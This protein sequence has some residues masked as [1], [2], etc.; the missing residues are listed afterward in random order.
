[1]NS[2]NV[3]VACAGQ[4]AL[5]ALCLDE[6][7]GDPTDAVQLRAR[8]TVS[9]ALACG[10]SGPPF[11]IEV[12]ASLLGLLVRTA[13]FG[14]AQFEGLIRGDAIYVRPGLAPARRRYVIAHEIIHHLIGGD[15]K[16]AGETQLRVLERVCQAGASE[17]LFPIDAFDHFCG[18][19]KTS[20]SLI[21]RV[22]RAFDVSVEAAARRCLAVDDESV[23]FVTINS[24]EQAMQWHSVRQPSMSALQVRDLVVIAAVGARGF[25]TRADHLRGQPVPRSSLI[26]RCY[27]SGVKR[28]WADAA[29]EQQEVWMVDQHSWPVRV[30]TA[31]LIMNRRMKHLLALLHFAA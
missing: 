3:E 11:D 31:P 9:D 24:V 25:Q 20:L 19:E 18:T 16:P 5:I 6:G 28:H 29:R 13:P 22:S 4:A 17:L 14:N 1:M 21:T 7:G 12:L 30:Q 10:W 27:Q 23:V 26:V 8:R 15:Q 2:D